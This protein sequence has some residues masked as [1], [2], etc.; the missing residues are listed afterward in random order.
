MSTLKLILATGLIGVSLTGCILPPSD[1]VRRPVA[2]YN[3]PYPVYQNRYYSSTERVYIPYG[4]R[5]PVYV[6]QPSRVV[7]HY[8][9]SER[10]YRSSWS[11]NWRDNNRPSSHDERFHP[12]SNGNKWNRNDRNNLPSQNR[13]QQGWH[14]Q[15]DDNGSKQIHNGNSQNQ[16]SKQLKKGWFN[17]D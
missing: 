1:Y 16:R 15:G 9:Y 11:K 2:H 6:S 13:P 12:V 4:V 17:K 7:S 10:D 3:T 5:Q 8:N 14:S